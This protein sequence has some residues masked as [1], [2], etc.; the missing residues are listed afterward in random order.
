MGTV[1]TQKKG[2]Y[3]RTTHI[4][5]YIY[6][7]LPFYPFRKKKNKQTHTGV[8]STC[9]VKRV[10]LLGQTFQLC[11]DNGNN[12]SFYLL[13]SYNYINISLQLYPTNHSFP[14]KL[15]VSLSLHLIDLDNVIHPQ[16]I[17]KVL[18]LL[19]FIT[20]CEFSVFFKKK[21]I[22]YFNTLHNLYLFFVQ[23]LFECW[24][25]VEKGRNVKFISGLFRFPVL[26]LN[27]S[28]CRSCDCQINYF[29][30]LILLLCEK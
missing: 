8:Q 16:H 18:S 2:G 19:L 29:S 15:T 13:H 3:G 9:W 10:H 7:Y 23:F 22:F 14:L 30:L 21:F 11:L 24:E 6:I 4:Y 1:P 27:F 28:S 20:L 12:I 5:I 25:T 26:Y 17:L